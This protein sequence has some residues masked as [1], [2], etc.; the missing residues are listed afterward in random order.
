MTNYVV[1]EFKNPIIRRRVRILRPKEYQVL[2]QC[3]TKSHHRTML[4]TLL[5]TGM[6][7]IELQRLQE[8]PSWFDGDFINLPKTADRKVKR[9][10]PERTV[11]LNQTGKTIIE[12]FLRLKEPLPAYQN[13]RENM[14]RWGTRA[15]L[16]PEGLGVKT[17]RKTWES[18]LM[19]FYTQTR[20]AEIALSQGHDTL[21]S[22]QHYLNMPFTEV[23]RLEMKPMVEGW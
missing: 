8:H 4:Q 12:Y 14:R 13:W 18:W 22:L 19:F 5:Y 7:Y 2:L 15:K 9:T 16:N 11:R 23:D 3:C 21:T 20:M 6:R 1:N 17:T 10:Q